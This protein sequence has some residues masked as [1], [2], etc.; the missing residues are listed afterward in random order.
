VKAG[1]WSKPAA[2]FE[3]T[4]SFGASRGYEGTRRIIVIF[5]FG[6]MPGFLALRRKSL[7]PEMMAH[8]WHDTFQ[9]ALL[10]IITRQRLLRMH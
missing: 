3:I 7:R 6:V 4:R 5:V 10:F 9:G 2:P 8:A 1:S